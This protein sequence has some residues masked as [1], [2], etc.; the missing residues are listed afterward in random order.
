MVRGTAESPR[1][2]RRKE[3][4]Q[5]S[6][7]HRDDVRKT[8]PALLALKTD[9]GQESGR[10]QPPGLGE[11]GKGTPPRPAEGARPD[12]SPARPSPDVRPQ[13]LI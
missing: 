12:R 3:T 6:Q 11:T 4:G 13:D 2:L 1:A 10:R 5:K 7:D 9:K 8:W